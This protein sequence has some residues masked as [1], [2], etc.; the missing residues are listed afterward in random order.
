MNNKMNNIESAD[1]IAFQLLEDMVKIKIDIEKFEL[2]LNSLKMKY[3]NTQ[4]EYSKIYGST[5]AAKEFELERKEKQRLAQE[6]DKAL[7]LQRQQEKQ[8]KQT[9]YQKDESDLIIESIDL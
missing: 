6:L 9:I 8:I 7:F 4:N 2:I 5:T 3:K 1:L